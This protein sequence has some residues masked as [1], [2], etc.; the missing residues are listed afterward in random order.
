MLLI[1]YYNLQKDIYDVNQIFKEIGSMVHEQ[2][3]TIDS[4]EANVERTHYSVREGATQLKQASD[5]S[6]SF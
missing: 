3:E 2:G 1:N 4:I 5:L 6:V